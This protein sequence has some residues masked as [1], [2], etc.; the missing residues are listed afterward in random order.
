MVNSPSKEFQ[1]FTD[2]QE[3]YKNIKGKL[4][5][6]LLIRFY[7]RYLKT[8]LKRTI[9]GKQFDRASY[10]DANKYMMRFW[11]ILGS[12]TYIFMGLRPSL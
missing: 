9:V 5:D 3:K 12:S 10:F 1:L 8:Q 7:L 2:E 6:K 4:I 11:S